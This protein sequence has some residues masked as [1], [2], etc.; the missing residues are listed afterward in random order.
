[1]KLFKCL[2]CRSEAVDEIIYANHIAYK[3]HTCGKILPQTYSM[4]SRIKFELSRDN[5]PIHFMTAI[6]VANEK[7]EIL[8][9]NRRAYPFAWSLVMG[10]V[11]N[12]EDTDAAAKR[13]LME[14]TALAADK[15]QHRFETTVNDPCDIGV[16]LHKI[17]AFKILAPEG[18]LIIPNSEV[19]EIR[20]FKPRDLKNLPSIS[21]KAKAVLKKEGVI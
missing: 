4:D 12:G 11:H 16:D 15:L 21:G 13:E 14:E 2:N 19:S 6:I 7:N 1:M 9:V 8:M 10:H 17:H 20:W 18:S 5:K 3:C